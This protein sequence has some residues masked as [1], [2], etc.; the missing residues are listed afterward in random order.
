MKP[1]VITA[2]VLALLLGLALPVGAQQEAH[3]FIE[4]LKAYKAGDFPSA[5]AGF[6]AVARQGV[7]NGKLYYNLGN[8]HLKNNDLGRA[9]LWYERAARLIPGDP[10]LTF[11]LDYARSLAKDAA[12]ETSPSLVRIFFF[13]KYQLS[14]RT[15]IVLAVG[16]NLVFWCL[17]IAWRL[18]GKRVLRRAAILVLIPGVVFALTAGFNYYEAAHFRQGII[19]PE[20]VPVR[21][22]WEP[23]STELF[24]LHA[25]AKVQVVKTADDHLLIRFPTDK[26]GWIHRDSLGLI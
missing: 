18:T 9:I 7:R 19:L 15:I 24:V 4:A 25:G 11:N 6:E 20:A 22:G 16:A 8:A 12:E 21:S 10:D 14:A 3:Q 23:N 26:I 17:A 13:W 2:T 5:V 1:W